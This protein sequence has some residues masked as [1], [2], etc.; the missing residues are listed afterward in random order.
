MVWEGILRFLRRRPS[1]LFALL[2]TLLMCWFHC[3]SDV[4]VSPKYLAESVSDKFWLWRVYECTSLCFGRP[5]LK[6]K[7]LSILNCICHMNSHSAI[8]FNSFP[9]TLWVKAAC[10]VLAI[11]VLLHAR[12]LTLICACRI[13]NSFDGATRCRGMTRS[14]HWRQN[15]LQRDGRRLDLSIN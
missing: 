3:K 9:L 14:A 6:M 1:I 12:V 13:F 4:I 11:E 5:T 15:P 10:F 8:L 2:V 7:H